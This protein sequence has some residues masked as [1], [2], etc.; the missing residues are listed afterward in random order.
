MLRYFDDT[1]VVGVTILTVELVVPD[2][3][4][5]AGVAVAELDVADA[6]LEA[7]QVVEQPQRLDNHGGTATCEGRRHG[8]LA[9]SIIILVLYIHV[10]GLLVYEAQLNTNTVCFK[11]ALHTH[12]CSCIAS[13]VAVQNRG[14]SSMREVHVKNQPVYL[15]IIFLCK[16]KHAIT[17]PVPPCSVSTSS[18]R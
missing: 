4:V 12:T 5:G 15:S 7:P 8:F 9:S 13:G 16:K 11:Q 2:A 14:F 6:A 18:C 3:D 10:M 17:Y 1:F